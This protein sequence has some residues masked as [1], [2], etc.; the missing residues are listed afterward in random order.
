MGLAVWWVGEGMGMILSGTAS[1]LT[2]AP[3]AALLYA[4]VAVLAWPRRSPTAA[5]E[6][7]AGAD[8]VAGAGD[9]VA[10]ASPLG[11]WWAKLGWLAVWGLAA[12]FFLQSANTARG[13]LRTG[14]AGLG[15]GEPGWV[16]AMDRGVAA[17]IGSGGPAVS[18][19]AAV[20]FAVIAVGVFVPAA[21]RPVLVL[22]VVTAAA[23]WVLGENFGGV[24][25][26]HGTDPSTGAL[27]ILLAAACWPLAQATR[28]AAIPS[29]V[30]AV[31]SVPV[32][33]APVT[34]APVT[35]RPRQVR[36]PGRLGGGSRGVQCAAP[37]RMKSDARKR[38]VRRRKW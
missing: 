12:Y 35:V 2:G 8:S 5:R 15:A 19:A 7:V 18:V 9:S 11:R 20:I 21:T 6:R 30:Q 1:P 22:A 32:T 27:L 17:T 36:R 24:L 37:L 13:T 14:I 23:I 29:S 33:V 16:A 25:T 10:T 3:G 34:V 4:L 28:A 31:I 38:R 26:A